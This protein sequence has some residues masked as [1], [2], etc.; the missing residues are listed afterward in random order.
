MLQAAR[1]IKAQLQDSVR[2][3]LDEREGMSPGWKFND[4]EMR[5][6]LC[7][8]KLVLVILPITRLCLQDATNPDVKGKLLFQLR[9][10]QP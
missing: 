7:A 8:L 2:V 1:N 3:K 10:S 4:W 6:Y 9:N 5:G